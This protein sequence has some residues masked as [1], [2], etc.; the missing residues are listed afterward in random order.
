VSDHTHRTI[1][2]LD[3]FEQL[4]DAWDALVRGMETP[5][6]FMLHGWLA[7]WW[8]E[9]GRTRR[10]AVQAAFRDG[11]LVAGLPFEVE[12]RGPLRV[13]SFMGRQHAA[14]A[15]VVA[16][17]SSL[18]RTLARPLLD[19][20][21]AA[22][23]PDYFDLFGIREGTAITTALG[24]RAGG[25]IQRVES[26]VLDLSQGWDAVYRA[27]TSSKRRNLHG[28]R[29]RQLREEGA[30]TVTVHSSP[31]EMGPV[32]EE[33]FRLHELRWRGRPDG[34]GFATPEG[35]LFNRAAAVRL[36]GDGVARILVLSVA[37]VAVAFHYYFV[38]EGRMY[39][40]R[41][42][43][44]P[45]LGKH[46]PGLLA[47]LAALEA[48]AGEGVEVVEYL[49]GG[50]R[51]KLE[52]SDRLAPMYELIG[53]P[54]S[55]RGRVAS[56]STR[57]LIEA[58]LRLKEHDRA[59]EFYFETLAPARRLLER[60]DSRFGRRREHPAEDAGRVGGSPRDA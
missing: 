38:L 55:L 27:K 10:M 24:H 1:G 46:S 41:L 45:R 30:V 31:D 54:R 40:Y 3:E 52:L 35:R 36:A 32:I 12:N 6:P 44:D 37:G 34:S 57:A 13:A 18:A 59:R 5:T 28:R 2:D 23:S 15:D 48:A 25:M 11:E 8:R 22:L 14:L 29:W 50:E 16:A 53:L 58:R 33:A 42:A 4:K 26:P 51:Y 20:V 49:G 21:G 17:D 56:T 47:T 7:E 43:F 19:G 9:Y 60:V 39:V